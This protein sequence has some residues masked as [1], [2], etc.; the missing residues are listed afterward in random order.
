MIK[1]IILAIFLIWFGISALY[2]SIVN[3]K[4]FEFIGGFLLCAGLWLISEII[5]RRKKPRYYFGRWY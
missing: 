2:T 3:S 1:E 4:Y 5:R